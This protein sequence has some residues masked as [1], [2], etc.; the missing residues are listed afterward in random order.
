[1]AALRNHRWPWLLAVLAGVLVLF[2]LATPSLQSRL[3]Q[4][5]ARQAQEAGELQLA[6]DHLGR[7][8]GLRPYRLD[9]WEQAGLLAWQ[10]GQPEQALAWLQRAG[11][12]R[13][14]QGWLAMGEAY[15]RAGNLK[16]AVETWQSELEISG[17]TI[18]L[19]DHLW[20]GYLK[21]EDYPAATVTLKSL[22]ALRPEDG[23]LHYRL[24]L[25]LAAQ[26]PES[27][28]EHLEAAQRLSPEQ[29]KDAERLR[30][31]ILAASLTGDRAYTLVNAGQALADLDEW[32]LA[33]QAFTR[34]TR[35]NPLFAEAWAYLGEAR[36][37]QPQVESQFSGRSGGERAG[38][39]E[40][41]RA[42]ALD[43]GSLSARLFLSLYWSRAGRYD[44][45]GETIRSGLRYHPREA[46]LYL[47]LGQVLARSGDLAEAA[48][49]YLQAAALH[50]QDPA[51]QRRIVEFALS[52]N[53][54]LEALALPAARSA[55]E[56]GPK[57]ARNL[58]TLGQVLIRLGELDEANS[59]LH[60]ALEVD[61]R[62]AS[63]HLHLG[64][65]LILQGDIAG[66]LQELKL[67]QNL[68][69]G[70][71][72]SDQAERLIEGMLK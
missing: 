67:A 71:S 35:E 24:G 68:A 6:A 33:E 13:T 37:H 16:A 57:D 58:D 42:L 38:L 63:A 11:P 7:A 14:P 59:L 21:L 23:Q 61:A 22:L 47:E 17:P 20:Q 62:N 53:Y 43:P 69:P 65:L 34:A 66:A 8:A 39:A 55:V 15:E 27:A 45:A 41:Q 49:A 2:G 5:R 54:Q 19:L 52:Q 40:I 46:A 56:L 30:G 10:A 72:I 31:K 36:Q 51:Y 12:G 28:V 18:D 50:P 64:A 60:Q 29:A 4:G 25:L 26:E 9:L 44:L 70:S 3:E 1:M 32:Q 48:R